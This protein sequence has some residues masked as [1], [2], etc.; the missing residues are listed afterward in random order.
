MYASCSYSSSFRSLPLAIENIFHPSVIPWSKSCTAYSCT[1]YIFPPM[2]KLAMLVMKLTLELISLSLR[3][4]SEYK[5]IWALLAKEFLL[6]FQL[7]LPSADARRHLHLEFFWLKTSW[8]PDLWG[9]YELFLF[10]LSVDFI[11]C[12]FHLYS[13]VVQEIRFH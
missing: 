6:Q 3:L 7:I 8:L 10:D 2:W 5:T 11:K 4:I 1:G 13:M 12:R 9:K